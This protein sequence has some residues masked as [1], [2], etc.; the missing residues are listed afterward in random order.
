MG[1]RD[2]R[3]PWSAT[4]QQRWAR[5]A[6]ALLA[7]LLVAGAVLTQVGTMVRT[8]VGAAGVG[9]GTFPVVEIAGLGSNG[10]RFARLTQALQD[11]GVTVLDM[12]PS[13]PGTQ[14]L[15]YRPQR[16]EHV[17]ELARRV[18]AP[19]VRAALQRAGLRPD[20][21]VDVVAHSMGGLLAR[22]LV[23]TDRSWAAQVDDLVMVA[24]PN[25]GSTLIAWE[26][27][28]GGPFN[29][30]GAD[31]R[32]GSELLTA[33]GTAE[34]PGEVYTTIGGDPWMFRWLRY[35][36]HGFDNTVPT[37]SPFL[38]GAAQDSFP[39][40]HGN[41]LRSAEVVDLVVETLAAR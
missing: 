1:L 9:R 20:A 40:T 14:P 16:D 5:A 39:A 36:G 7:V 27:A 37:V 15:T 28:G 26:T 24:T 4:W 31:M 13:R 32:P 21:V 18:V 17:P 41:L 25:H 22:S 11:R 29:A 8:P 34:P 3:P 35:G 12:D 19:A 2:V 30:L 38:T 23:E 33:L 6:L 10:A